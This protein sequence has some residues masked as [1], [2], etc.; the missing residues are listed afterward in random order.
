MVN[1]HAQLT[2]IWALLSNRFAVSA[3]AHTILAGLTTAALVIF[4]VSCWHLLRGRNLEIFNRAAA[5]ALVVAVPVTIVNLAVGSRFGI[6]ATDLQPVKIS[7]AEALWDTQQP[8]SFSLF[9]IGG[10]SQS[11][12]TPSFSIEVPGLLSFLATGSFDGKVVGLDQLQ[13]QYQHQ[14]GRSGDYIP[15]VEPLYWGM[16]V[17]AYLGT[18]MALVAVVGAVLYRRGTLET[19]RWF[20]RIAMWTM[21]FPFAAA[22]AGWVLTE[23][24][25]Q[26][27]IVQGLLRTSDANS[28]SVSTDTIAASITVFALLYLTLG[29]VDFVLMRRYA[30]LDPPD[31][32][33]R[34]DEPAT[35]AVSY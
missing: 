1:G 7:G 12:P 34:P 23:M 31:A 13:R 2:S 30:R 35:P 27:W 25:R 14:Y 19:N 11:D 28:P 9:Q 17:M 16:R 26:P 29:V 10:F 8:A 21:A 15:N 4:G 24:G 3:F 33:P 20:L 6:V 18:L 22:A 32:G 5:L